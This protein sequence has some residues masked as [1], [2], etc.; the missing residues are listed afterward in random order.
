MAVG[1]RAGR[2]DVRVGGS[3]VAE[4][5]VRFLVFGGG[6]FRMVRLGFSIYKLVFQIIIGIDCTFC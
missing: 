5:G 3:L 4:H 1:D 6:K 2:G